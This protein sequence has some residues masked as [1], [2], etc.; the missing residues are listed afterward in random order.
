[1]S[2]VVNLRMTVAGPVVVG[3]AA[4]NV[5]GQEKSQATPPAGVPAALLTV[6]S[7]PGT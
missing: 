2:W 6:P 5:I 7:A 1:M 3:E 4:W